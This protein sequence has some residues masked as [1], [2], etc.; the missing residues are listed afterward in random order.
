MNIKKLWSL[1]ALPLIY[2]IF[3]LYPVT[4]QDYLK[5]EVGLEKLPE[6]YSLVDIE[7]YNQEG[8]EMEIDTFDLLEDIYIFDLEEGDYTLQLRYNNEVRFI[9]FKRREGYQELPKVFFTA[10]AFDK[11]QSV[12]LYS[13]L[14]ITSLLI[15]STSKVI[16][17]HRNK[18]LEVATYS[19]L[20]IISLR[21]VILGLKFYDLHW[22]KYVFKLSLFF[23]VFLGFALLYWVMDRVKLPLADLVKR[24]VGL[25]LILQIIFTGFLLFFDFQRIIDLLFYTKGSNALIFM[26]DI[27]FAVR[28]F[29]FPTIATII[30]LSSIYP[31]VRNTSRVKWRKEFSF[32]LVAAVLTVFSWYYTFH[33]FE[34]GRLDSVVEIYTFLSVFI[35]VLFKAYIFSDSREYN[36]LRYSFWW[37]VRLNYIT[38]L[39]YIYLIYTRNFNYTLTV[40]GVILMTDIFYLNLRNS[41]E[42]QHF[43]MSRI[44]FKE[45]EVAT[46]SQLKSLVEGEVGKVIPVS[47]ISLDVDF[48]GVTPEKDEE[49]TLFF[50]GTLNKRAILSLRLSPLYPLKIF[51]RRALEELVEELPGVALRI[52]YR[53]SLLEGPSMD[54]FTMGTRLM[55]LRELIL[56]GSSM[57]EGKVK[58]SIKESVL[59]EIDSLIEEVDSHV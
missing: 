39:A 34:N 22:W 58:D 27:L 56:L 55:E 16:N 32:T 21:F 14:F 18:L 10:S 24:G 26:C 4:P 52:H 6:I 25:L 11:K 43:S 29:L 12:F 46:L 15:L 54:S 17:K 7:V 9:P 49:G 48:N 3:L 33:E 47:H 5:I 51:E 40:L 57:E 50:T 59:K 41:V 20:A 8:Q 19:L 30:F 45:G 1:L 36:L 13:M 53:E 28:E 38:F 37:S 44:L 31:L 42:S 23:E 35:L 2:L